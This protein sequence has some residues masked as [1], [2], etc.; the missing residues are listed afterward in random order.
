M[1]YRLTGA[2][3]DLG[4]MIGAGIASLVS[5]GLLTVLCWFVWQTYDAGTVDWWALGAAVCCIPVVAWSVYRFF[6]KFLVFV[7]FGPSRLEISQYPLAPGQTVQLS[8]RQ[9]GQMR[10]HLLEVVLLCQEVV[11]YS[12][13]TNV[14]TETRN[15]VEQRLFRQRG[16][17]AAEPFQCEFE[18]AIPR[19]A[20]HSFSADSNRIQ[21]KIIVSASVRGWPRFERAFPII[22]QP[23]PA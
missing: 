14:R 11:T 6:L 13:G 21:W 10:L 4:W 20:M 16:I 7:A 15:V 5:V 9:P 12:Q 22:V 19:D 17:A 2:N 1:P 8:L 3:P 23:P 18:M